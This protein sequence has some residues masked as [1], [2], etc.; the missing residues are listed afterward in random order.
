[1]PSKFSCLLL[2][3]PL[4]KM[5]RNCLTMNVYF[6]LFLVLQLILFV[7]VY[8]TIQVKMVYYVYVISGV[9]GISLVCCIMSWLKDPGY[10]KKAKIPFIQLLD[11]F[12]PTMLCPECEVIRTARSRHC[13]ICN[14]CIE[15]FDHHC[16]WINN[17]VGMKNHYV[18]LFF[19]LFTAITVLLTIILC[20]VYLNTGLNM[21]N[22]THW[23]YWFPQHLPATFYSDKVLFILKVVCISISGIFLLPLILL[24][25]VQLRNFCSG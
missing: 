18:F 16:P 15:R 4:K 24:T 3:T 25:F 13:S 14:R 12:D 19:L 6:F 10:L 5:K 20:S 11:K 1:M 9:S 17:C 2:K 7:F 21:E 8:P 23:T 22:S